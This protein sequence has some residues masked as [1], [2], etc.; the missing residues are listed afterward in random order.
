[1]KKNS[2]ITKKTGIVI[3]TRLTVKLSFSESKPGAKIFMKNGV[4]IKK[5]TPISKDIN[6]VVLKGK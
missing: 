3:R 5:I 6:I 2:G 1:M 4:K